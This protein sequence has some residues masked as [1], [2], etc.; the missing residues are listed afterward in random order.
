MQASVNIMD[1]DVDMLSN[2]VFVE[3]INDCLTNEKLQVI[4]FASTEIITGIVE[5]G[6]HQELAEL[7][8]LLLPG[9]EALLSA[10]HEEVLEAGDMV[11][12]CRSFGLALQRLTKKSRTIYIIS[13]S[14][15]DVELLTSYCTA[16]QPDIKIVGSCVYKEGMDDV[17]IVNDINSHVPDFLIV[18]LE[19][20]RQ[21]RWILEQA[22]LLN[23]RL[24]V[25]I[26][27]V[28]GIIK[29]QQ[30]ETPQWI[31]KIHLGDLYR[32]VVQEQSVKKD[33]RAR[34]FRKK[35]VHYNNQIEEKKEDDS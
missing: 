21:E 27:G 10:H 13:R 29:S 31:E 23:A 19:T 22:S 11:V 2:D 30:K 32:K 34:I 6:R 26:G 33:W 12:S 14:E 35:V 18:D 17:A 20:G 7:A 1:V 3:K 16:M 25:A 15:L 5:G 8:E 28:S 4:Y 24:C 9:E